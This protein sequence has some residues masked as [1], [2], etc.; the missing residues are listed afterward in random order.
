LQTVTKN[1]FHKEWVISRPSKRII[2][3]PTRLREACLQI[4]KV[5]LSEKHSR[6]S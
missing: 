6:K 3:F 5:K 4:D 2:R 1:W